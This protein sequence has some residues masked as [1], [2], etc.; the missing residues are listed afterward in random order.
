MTT[1]IVK[2]Q[3]ALIISFLLLTPAA[4]FLVAVC[5]PVGLAFSGFWS[6]QKQVFEEPGNKWLMLLVNLFVLVGPL[7][8]LSVNSIAF[9][10]TALPSPPGTFYAGPVFY[11]SR[12]HMALALLSLF[13][14]VGLREF[15]IA[16]NCL[17]GE[18]MSVVN[19]QLTYTGPLRSAEQR[20]KK[21]KQATGDNLN[22]NY[23][24]YQVF[25]FC[26]GGNCLLR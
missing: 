13:I 26:M 8:A 15:L 18:N 11:G 22:R 19:L 16:R 20:V 1:R 4:A 25:P 7:L 9:A 12:I 10:G 17:P 2:Q 3:K 24:T 14:L 21:T 23:E 6:T 5:L